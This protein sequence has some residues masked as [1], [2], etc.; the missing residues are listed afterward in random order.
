MQDRR[1]EDL[2]LVE[3]ETEE[4]IR[5][6]A[7][8][9]SIIHDEGVGVMTTEL[10]LRHPEADRMRW[11]VY[12]EKDSG[13]IV[14]TLC[15]LPWTFMYGSIPVPAGEL[16]IVG[17]RKDWR[18]RGLIRGLTGR[19][20][21][22]LA[23]EGYLVSMIQGIAYFYRQF[24]YEY[25]I[26]LE[27]QVYLEFRHIAP[28]KKEAPVPGVSLRAASESDIPFLMS[29]YETHIA[30]FGICA[31]RSEAEWRFLLGPSMRTD[32]GA[33]T[34]TIETQEDSNRVQV[35]YCRIPRKGFGEALILGEC[36]ELEGPLFPGLFRELMKM[37]VDREKPFIRLNLGPTHS[38]V[39]A[40]IDAGA[41][42][43]DPYGWQI[44]ISDPAGFLRRILPVLNARLAV[45]DFG[46]QSGIFIINSFKG[47]IEILYSGGEIKEIRDGTGA[48]GD[49]AS[50]PPNLL[51][52]LFLGQKNLTECKSFYPDLEGSPRSLRLFSTLFTPMDA[53]LHCPY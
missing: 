50:I 34:Y 37:A 23:D 15:L 40:A 16:G 28:S 31:R 18:N 44:R 47:K 19:F 30:T 43:A 14:S 6:L 39:K 53:F 9:S 5:A 42:Q 45:S 13:D 26:P 21:Q 32:Y 24:G 48:K 1:I 2:D 35:G 33:D 29:S 8:F 7:A 4:E 52:P 11:L 49:E 41:M 20:N 17:T 10:A 22:I 3:L 46:G 51:G 38:A 36:S 27:T 12:K 25:A